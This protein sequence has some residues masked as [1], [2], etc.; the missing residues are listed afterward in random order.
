MCLPSYTSQSMVQFS[1]EEKDEVSLFISLH[2]HP[3]CLPVLWIVQYQDPLKLAQTTPKQDSCL[4]FSK[5]VQFSFIMLGPRSWVLGG[6]YFQL[7]RLVLGSHSD[8]AA[9]PRVL[10]SLWLS[11]LLPIITQSFVFLE[12]IQVPGAACALNGGQRPTTS[13]DAEG[14]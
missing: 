13:Q 10:N 1:R 11:F 6:F 8:H 14:Q 4:F 9:T 3:P 12:G 7:Q 2:H 5:K